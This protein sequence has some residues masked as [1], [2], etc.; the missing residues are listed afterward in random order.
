MNTFW[1]D[2]R[3]ALRS[4]LRT[5]GFTAVAVLTLALGIGANTAI[6]SVLNA[7]LFHPL[8]YP[9]SARLVMVW[10]RF[11]DIGLPNDRNWVSAPEFRDLNELSRSFSGLGAMDQTTF[12]LGLSGRPESAQGARVS[13]ALFSILAVQPRLGRTF[14][15]AEAQPG[16]DRVIVLSDGLWR[17]A[18]A[19]DPQ[20]V[21]RDIVVSGQAMNVVGV[22]P[23]GFEFPS[24]CELWTPLAFTPDAFTPNNRGSHGL[25][26][27]ARIRP[28]L[29]LEQAR[30]DMAAVS[31]SIIEKARDYPYE[32]FHFTV[33]LN[34]LLEETVGDIRTSLWVLMG[35]VGFVLLLACANIA[36]LLLV[37][38]SARQREIA[39]RVALGAGTG[40]VVRQMLTESVALS[41]MGGLAGLLLTPALLKLL[42]TFSADALPRVVST[43]ID[44]RAL[45]F[46]LAVALGTGV[47]F[48]LAPA[49]GARHDLRYDILKEGG[50]TTTDGVGA[51]RLRRLFV[52]AQAALALV[53]LACSGLLLRSFAEI[54][55]LDP[56]FRPEGVL[57]AQVVLPVQKYPQPE[58]WRTF[59]NQLIARVETL[60]GVDA[61][62]SVAFLPLSGQGSSGTVTVDTQ[63]VPPDKS[64]PEADWRPVSPGFFRAMGVSLIAGRFFDARDTDMAPPVAIIDETL[65][66]TYWTN[67]DA[68]GKR[69]H[70][71]GMKS[72]RPWMT[73]VGVVRHVR[74]RTLEEPSRITLYWPQAQS[75][76]PFIGLT[77]R[78]SQ[79]PLSLA[80]A[81]QKQVLE[82]DPEQ[83]V[84][85]IRTMQSLMADSLARRRLTMTLLALFAGGALLLAALGIYG[86]TAYTVT[87]RQ[88]E[89]GLRMA[90]GASRP[91][92]LRLIIRQG[93]SLVLAGL[94]AGLLATLILARFLSTLLFSVR[95]SDPLTL[96]AAALVLFLVALAACAIPAYRAARVDPMIALRYE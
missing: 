33:L 43:D 83:P 3:F 89:I 63:A 40:R 47:L 87:Q 54:L 49:L 94:A 30:S 2:F 73:I 4:F 82:L 60:P 96:L 8:P 9:D 55:K 1:Q 66:R 51:R 81:I 56:G 90:L 41:V 44:L 32:K 72:T 27:L 50:R 25:L 15:P 17:R 12:N 65:A 59:F 71:G 48:G 77:V 35:A 67:G 91:I 86:V 52:A 18:F 64:T 88:Q 13:P 16:H 7:V 31:R 62:G 10:M 28:E 69:I 85:H 78:T 6:F 34:P 23:P 93:L 45:L 70:R 5:P 22:M 26:V 20:V 57:T 68:V 46:T 14:L 53:L 58:N 80:T 76:Y 29:S 79:D 38:S 39:I 19:A 61:A 95:P 42:V 21:G 74:Y 11:T 36:G 92:V 37:R 75:P 84:D 24:P